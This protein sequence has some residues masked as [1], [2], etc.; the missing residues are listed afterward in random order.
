MEPRVSPKPLF[1]GKSRPALPWKPLPYMEEYLDNLAAEEASEGYISAMRVS[2]KR[3]A[4]FCDLEGIKHPD[5]IERHHLLRYQTYLVDVLASDGRNLTLAY[6]QRLMKNLRA[7]INWMLEVE[8]ITTNPWVRIRVGRQTKKPK[9]LE[10]D[11]LDALFAAHRQQAFSISPFYYHRREV[12]LTLLFAWGLR[13]HELAD[14]TVAKMDMRQE[15]V[16]SRNKG[17]G[18]KTLPYSTELKQVVQR[19]LVQRSRKA[20]PQVDNLLIDSHGNPLSTA[21]I[22]KIVV[23]CG[24]R[25]GVALNPHRLRDTCGTTLLDQDVPVERIM[26]ILGHSQRSQTLAYSR[27]NDPKVKES[28]DAVMNPLISRLIGGGAP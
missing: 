21:M 8:H 5:E 10:E 3:F 20:V 6:R 7:W 23:E 25:G 1:G 4:I 14:L 27:L 9:P 13:I 19:W 28:H 16:I 17:G 15:F 26:K 12:I 2:F 24:A 22:Y 11:E 18:S